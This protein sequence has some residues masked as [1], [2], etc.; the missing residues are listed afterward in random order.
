MRGV[1]IIPFCLRTNFAF[2]LELGNGSIDDVD[3][4]LITNIGGI[5]GLVALN[6]KSAG[7]ILSQLMLGAGGSDCPGAAASNVSGKMLAVSHEGRIEQ[8]P[9]IAR[10]YNNVNQ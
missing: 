1:P 4:I 5:Y 3:N 2:P 10:Q 6:T 7:A 8:Y 9:H